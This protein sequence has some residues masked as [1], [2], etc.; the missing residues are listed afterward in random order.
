MK[1]I[2]KGNA[3]RRWDVLPQQ[4]ALV[5]DL[6]QNRLIVTAAVLQPPV[7]D[8]NRG[9]SALFGSYGALVGHE[10]NRGFDIRGRM[11]DANGELRDWWT[12]ADVSAWNA[13]GAR[14]TSQYGGY[15]YPAVG[16]A[17][18]NGALTQ[19]ENLGDLA[20]V[21]LAWD[22]F[23]NAQLAPNLGAKQTLFRSWSELWAQQITPADAAQRIATDVHAPGQWRSNGPLAN[24]PAFGESFSCKAGQP[25]R[26]S[27]AEQIKLWR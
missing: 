22:A 27:D 17:K 25:M 23:T 12:P 26:R 3:D 15:A 18:V 14:V 10:L 9:D 2:G 1:R 21:E 5:Y 13:I 16:N 4:P 19:D 6:A 11:V 20:G 8:V 24:Q 7:F